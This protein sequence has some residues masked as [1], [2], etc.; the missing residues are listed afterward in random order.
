LEED[1]GV[2]PSQVPVDMFTASGSGLDPEI[3]PAA[4]E[5]QVKRV[6]KARGISEEAVRALIRSHIRSRWAGFLG[7]PVLTS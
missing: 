1:P 6:A 7:A 4:A 5:I 2:R 3:S